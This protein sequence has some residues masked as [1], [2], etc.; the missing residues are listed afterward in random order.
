MVR[1]YYTPLQYLWNTFSE[2]AMGR[3]GGK[4][5]SGRWVGGE[6]SLVF[7]W[8]VTSWKLWTI[9]YIVAKK[10]P[11][12]CC[13]DLY[14]WLWRKTWIAFWALRLTDNAFKT[15]LKICWMLLCTRGWQLGW[16]YWHCSAD[17]PSSPHR[18]IAYWRPYNTHATLQKATFNTLWWF[19]QREVLK[20]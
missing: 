2:Q 11:G 6:W 17:T 9:D 4:D 18:W 14:S 10:L 1:V 5:D 7:F 16:K 3:P 12:Q 13:F 19:W 15:L 8:C 20:S